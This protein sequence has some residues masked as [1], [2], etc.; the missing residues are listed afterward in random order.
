MLVL[1]RR[2]GEEILIGDNVRLVVVSV[3]GNQVR[4]GFEAPREVPV[5]RSEVTRCRCPSMDPADSKIAV[6]PSESP[7]LG[8]LVLSQ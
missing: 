5:R 4:L 1:G 2:V 8:E 7:N 6:D 3:R